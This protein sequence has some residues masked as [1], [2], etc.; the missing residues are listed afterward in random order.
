VAF[1]IAGGLTLT[2]FSPMLGG[3]HDTTPLSITSHVVTAL[4]PMAMTFSGLRCLRA[5]RG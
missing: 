2:A 5:A 1:F 4:M 3:H